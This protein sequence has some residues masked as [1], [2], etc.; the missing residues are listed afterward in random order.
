MRLK[1]DLTLLL[2]AIIWGSA[3]ITQ[4]IAAQYHL[5]YLFNGVSFMLAAVILIPFIPRQEKPP[6]AQYK[7][8]LIAGAVLFI[9][10][11]LQQVGIF[12]TKVANAGFL[13]SLYTVFTPFILWALFREKAHWVD[14]VAVSVASVGAFLLS[15]AGSFH[16]QAGD[17]LEVAG[18]VFWALHFVVLG[19]FASRFEPVSFAAGQFMVGGL[20]NFMIGLAT[21]NLG[22]LA[23]LPVIGAVLYRAVF[24]I[25]IGYTLQVWSQHH[26]PPTDAALILSLEGVFAMLAGWVMLHQSLLP[27]QLLGCL[28]IFS[29]V[30]FSQIKGLKPAQVNQVLESQQ[31]TRE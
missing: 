31:E 22:L 11:A 7:W 14:L 15:T 25:G 10:S 26:T 18:A 16:I 2:V 20:F 4:G 29:A 30:L 23:P 28:I 21:E 3:F 24:S 13:T 19:K 27:I 5:A 8:M 17:A 9:G 12:Y 6:E 1:A